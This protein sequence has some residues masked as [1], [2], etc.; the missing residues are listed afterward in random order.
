MVNF[1][2][3]R[4]LAVMGTR[5]QCE[6]I[7]KVTWQSPDKN[8]C[9]QLDHILVDRRYCMNVGEK[10]ERCLN[11]IRPLFSENQNYIEN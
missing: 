4:D 7:R 6:N 3:G 10:H 2:Q 1:P 11:R 5:Y 9:N 8:I